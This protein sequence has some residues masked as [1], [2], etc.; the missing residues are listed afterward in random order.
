MTR[1]N[2]TSTA[3]I[4]AALGLSALATPALAAPVTQY[5]GAC[6][7]LYPN[8]NCL[9]EGPGNP[10]HYYGIVAPEAYNRGGPGY[11]TSYAYYPAYPV[12]RTGFAPLDFAGDVAGAAVGTAGAIA[13]AP[14]RTYAW[15]SGYRY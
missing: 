5:P 2:L 3:I 7:S 11:P 10:R 4:G 1:L 6:R 8:A 12:Y 13:T 9:N 15:E 14:F